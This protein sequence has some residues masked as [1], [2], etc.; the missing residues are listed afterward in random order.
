MPCRR[1]APPAAPPPRSPG[2]SNRSR[3]RARCAHGGLAACVSSRAWPRPFDRLTGKRTS[4]Q[5]PGG[6]VDRRR[7]GKAKASDGW[8]ERAHDSLRLSL[9]GARVQSSRPPR[10]PLLPCR[11]A[12]S[13]ASAP[14]IIA[15]HCAPL[16]SGHRAP[17]S[18]TLLPL[19]RSLAPLS[20]RLPALSARL[21]TGS[22]TPI[23]VV[24]ARRYE[25]QVRQAAAAGHADPAGAQG[26]LAAPRR[27]RRAGVVPPPAVPDEYCYCHRHR[28]CERLGWFGARPAVS[29]DEAPAADRERPRRLRRH[30]AAPAGRRRQLVRGRQEAGAHGV[31][32]AAQPAMTPAAAAASQ[33]VNQSCSLAGQ[34]QWR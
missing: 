6:A 28:P 29:P 4:G 16:F 2:Q 11:L 31:Q 8:S 5:R 25:R 33:L 1:G 21:V 20:P 30:E 24:R 12:P 10:P 7:A 19:A 3:A 27:P 15:D 13:L 23:L 22:T 14:R 18:Y 34:R 9:P 17:H 32:P 26:D